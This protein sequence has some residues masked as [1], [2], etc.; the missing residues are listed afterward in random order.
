MKPKAGKK[1]TARKETYCS[2]EGQETCRC[3]RFGYYP[4]SREDISDMRDAV[5]F[6]VKNVEYPYYEVAA[7]IF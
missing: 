4:V 3:R 1:R 7:E 6:E 2:A 5:R